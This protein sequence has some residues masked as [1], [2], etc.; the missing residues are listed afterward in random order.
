MTIETVEALEKIE[1]IEK[2]KK[3]Q[4]IETTKIGTRA[5]TEKSTL[6]A[7]RSY[8]LNTLIVVMPR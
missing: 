1:T 7:A 5:F 6:I 2:I 4:T 8:K 3:I